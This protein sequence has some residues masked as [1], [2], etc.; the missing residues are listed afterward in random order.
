MPGYREEARIAGTKVVVGTGGPVLTMEA[1]CGGGGWIH[2]RV[3]VQGWVKGKRQ[4][5]GRGGEK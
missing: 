4:G 1:V 5:R 3:W 2:R